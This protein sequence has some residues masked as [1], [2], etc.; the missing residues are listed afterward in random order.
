M[1]SLR[2]FG[3]DN[4]EPLAQLVW[5]FFEYWAWRHDYSADVI[6]VRTGGFLRK[7]DRDWTRRIGN[8]RHL[9]SDEPAAAAGTA[10]I[11][12]VAVQGG[13]GDGGAVLCWVVAPSSLQCCVGRRP[14]AD[15]GRLPMYVP[16]TSV[17]IRN[18]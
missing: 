8:E 17:D 13:F 12:P 2:D 6:S 15:R 4:S 5:S 14:L 7:E 18:R 11:G 1:D 16:M 3:S 10:T 9:V